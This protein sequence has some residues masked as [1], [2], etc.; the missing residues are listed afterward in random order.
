MCCCNHRVL[1]NDKPLYMIGVLDQGWNP[2]G[3][4]L[5]QCWHLGK[6]PTKINAGTC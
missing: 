2:D 4:V 3:L 5:T 1:L 6:A